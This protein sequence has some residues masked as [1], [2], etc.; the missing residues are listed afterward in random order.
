MSTKK[1]LTN[2]EKLIDIF[3][4][5]YLLHTVLENKYEALSYKKI[6]DILMKYPDEIHSSND[7]RGIPGIGNRTLLKVDE[8]LKTKKLKLLEELKK[9]KN[10]IAR[11]ELQKVMGIGPKLSRKLVE[12]NHIMSVKQLQETYKKGK[13]ELTHMQI[14]G[15]KYFNKL[16]AKIPRNE[17]TKYKNKFE[18]FLDKQFSDV[19]LHMAGSYR[20]GKSTSGDIDMILVSSKIKTKY[21]LDKSYIFDDIIDQLMKDKLIIEIIN[22]SKNG[23]MAITDT[24]R[25]IDIKMA[26]YNLLPF[27]LLYFGSGETYS[28]EIRQKAKDQGY[29]LSEW[30]LYDVKSNKI[31]LNKATSEEEIFNKL[32]IKYLKPM[33]R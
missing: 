24:H 18:K 17:I 12:K 9:N 32:G 28:R 10:I 25:H 13:I 16:T 19:Q 8:I 26:P 2:K 20:R 33:N 1:S 5:L 4:Q 22:R 14:T 11:L 6:V 27:F 23:I 29:R 15:L 7:L 21:D 3:N 31:V 30:G